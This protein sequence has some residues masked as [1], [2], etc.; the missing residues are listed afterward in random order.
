MCQTPML[1]RCPLHCNAAPPSTGWVQ[2]RNMPRTVAVGML[3][4]AMQSNAMLFSFGSLIKRQTTQVCVGS[5]VLQITSAALVHQPDYIVAPRQLHCSKLT[6]L[7][8]TGCRGSIYT[9]QPPLLAHFSTTHAATIHSLPYQQASIAISRRA[10][11]SEAEQS[12][13]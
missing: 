1:I 3:C 9:M 7:C 2:H 4:T 8:H 5:H 6:D 10:A 12:V 13:Q 11:N